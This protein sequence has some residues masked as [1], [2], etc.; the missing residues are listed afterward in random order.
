[1][2]FWYVV[3]APLPLLVFPYLFIESQAWQIFLA[4]YAIVFARYLHMR[5]KHKCQ[6]DI[7][8]RF[9]MLWWTISLGVF[10]VWCAVLGVPFACIYKIKLKH[11]PEFWES[12]NPTM[13]I[14]FKPFWRKNGR[15][16]LA[17]PEGEDPYQACYE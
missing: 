5:F 7:N 6:L 8:G 9:M 16:F 15:F 3:T 2:K 17:V 10:I 11:V 13:G 14:F 4:F 12:S 1:M